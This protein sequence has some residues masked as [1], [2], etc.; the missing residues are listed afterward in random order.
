MLEANPRLTPAAVKHILISTADR[1]HGAAAMRQG[2]GVL[3]ARRAVE[4]AARER[5][6]DAAC[7]ACPPRIEGGKLVFSYHD[8]AAR[9]VA[10][11]GDF[12]GWDP[13]R[14]RFVKRRAGDWRAEITPPPP[15]RYQYKF[16]VDEARWMDDPSNAV[17][18]P[19]S[20]GGL[21]SVINLA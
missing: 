8:D 17:K 12:N 15:G 2:Y 3:N 6:S 20:Y 21:N 14:A 4:V 11:A 13:A 1:I 18:E 7:F 10:L 9:S 16:V 5:H 19:D